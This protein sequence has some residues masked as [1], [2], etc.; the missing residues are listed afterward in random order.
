MIPSQDMA[1]QRTTAGAA[2]A[3]R[4]TYNYELVMVTYHSRDLLETFLPTLPDNIPLVI[5]D[6]AHGADRIDE[7]VSDRPATRYL[8]GPGTGFASGANL[9][10]RTST[11]DHLI[12]VSPDCSPTVEQFD[13]LVADL[14]RDPKL[15]VVTLTN[16]SPDG[17]V[18][19]MGGWEPTIRRA[20]VH[21]VG[22]HKLF[23]QAGLWATP[24]P[25]QPIELD[26]LGGACMAS[27]RELFCKLGGY[28][29][30]Y[31]LYSEDVDFSRRVRAE[32]L[33][34]LVRTDLLVRHL[35]TSSGGESRPRMLQMR[36]GSMM[37]YVRRHNS[38]ATAAGMR[39]ALT[40]GYGGR[41]LLCRL[42]GRR[43]TAA[44]HAAYIR[45]LWVGPPDQ[46]PRFERHA[47]Q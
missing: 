25:H 8:D 4:S 30:S 24:V 34:Q 11:A 38:P 42:R 45:G 29:E 47:L 3:P 31:F 17:S 10:A 1:A 14:E 33:R 44:E 43:G 5:V 27:P 37:Q 15:A 23:P 16:V 39:L 9:G 46:P 21:A 7:L 2:V 35:G 41:Y 19:I 28:D 40:A 20:L 13:E 32:G 6:N 26:W 22:A 12:F 36:G 18:E